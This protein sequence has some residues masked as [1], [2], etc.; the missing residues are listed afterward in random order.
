MTEMIRVY[1]N[2]RLDPINGLRTVEWKPKVKV[3]NSPR[4]YLIIY[5]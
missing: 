3:Y 1:S 4:I 2:P 5:A